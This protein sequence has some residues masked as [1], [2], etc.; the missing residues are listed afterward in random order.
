MVRCSDGVCGPNRLRFLGEQASGGFTKFLEQRQGYL[1]MRSIA[2]R[3]GACE[4]VATES[5]RGNFLLGIL[6]NAGEAGVSD[7]IWGNY[8]CGTGRRGSS[9]CDTA[10][11]GSGDST[12]VPL[13]SSW[14]KLRDARATRRVES[15]GLLS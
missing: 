8:S 14:M 13:G 3:Q 5:R 10:Q 9:A 2:N 15:S 7:H 6:P 4:A 11:R 1:S 12:C